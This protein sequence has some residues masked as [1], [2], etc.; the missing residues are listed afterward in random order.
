M[1]CVHGK[2]LSKQV[3]SEEIDGPFHCQTFP[4]CSTQLPFRLAQRST[5]IVHDILDLTAVSDPVAFTIV[6][7]GWV[8]GKLRQH[9]SDTRG[10]SIR[11]KDEGTLEVWER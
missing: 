8:G 9:C 3:G 6:A 10:I 7:R 4:M 11:M 5:S 1:I 2:V